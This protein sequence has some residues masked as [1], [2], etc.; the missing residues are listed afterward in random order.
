MKS[1]RFSAKIDGRFYYGYI[2]LICAFLPMFICYVIKVNCAPLF[3]TSIIE[4][5]D[6]TRTAYTQTNT[7]MTI[8]MMIAS[9]FIGNFYKKIPVKYALSGCVALTSACYLLMSFATNIWH[10]YILSA[11]QGVGWAG[12]TTLPTTIIVSNWF[13]PKVKGT[14]LSIA[15]LGSGVGA[16]V[17]IK[18]VTAIIDSSGW[19]T[20]FIAMAIINALVIPVVLILA[21]SMPRDR[22]FDRRVGDPTPDE[23]QGDKAQVSLQNTGITGKQTLTTA[24]WWLQFTACM[25]TMIG[26][27]AFS[28]YCKDFFTQITGDSD[29]SASIYAGALGTLVIGKFLL[30][31]ITDVLHVKRT[32][33]LAPLFYV[34]V[35]VCLALA[36]Q[37]MTFATV[38]IPFYMIGG[39]LPSVI[40]FLITAYNFGDKEFGVISGWMNVA[41]NIGQI[42]GPTVAAIIFDTTGSYTLAWIVCAVLMVV[43]A[44][45]YLLSSRMSAKKIADMGYVPAA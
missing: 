18:I 10:L 44:V 20:G 15:M 16:L 42:I 28:Y 1:N 27:S 39:A 41:G 22:G 3:V 2:M 36:A 24:R 14:A 33:V 37:N 12:A 5:L 31:V 32:A 19:R 8:T 9:L 26:A 40:P 17:W 25:V 43:V 34:G 21:V 23:S 45:L 13:G 6:I 7:V 29:L 4:E 30:G 38:M 35:F 11:I